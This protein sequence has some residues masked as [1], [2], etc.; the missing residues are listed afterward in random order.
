MC[1]MV[2]RPP[3]MEIA[4]LGFLLDGPQHGYQLH[5]M[6]SDPVGLGLIWHLKQSQL[7]ALLNKL[8]GDGC[9]TS[10]LQN[11]DPHPPRR[12]LELTSMGREAFMDWVSSPVT[13][14]RLIRQEFLAKLYFVS[15]E[16]ADMARQLIDKQRSV[17]QRWLAEFK[18]QI[19]AS[20]PQSYRWVLY[21]YRLGQIEALLQW[22]GSYGKD[23]GV[24]V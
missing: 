4:L 18:T 1:P 2:R 14:P 8:E 16:N 6:I 5:Q 10:T 13:T 9:I 11:Q 19:T 22:L 21:Q 12:V 23:L 20:E 7:Y 3:G 17:C 15:K 24:I